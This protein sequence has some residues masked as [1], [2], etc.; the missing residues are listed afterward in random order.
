M[1]KNLTTI[2][3]AL[4]ALA[5]VAS[6]CGGGDSGDGELVAAISAQMRE[7]GDIPDGFDVECM[8]GAM[9]EGLGGAEVMEEEFGLTAETIADGQEPED[10]EMSIDNAR[11]MA[12]DMRECGLDQA[13]ISEIAGDGIPEDSAQCLLD[14]LDS[15]ALRDIFASSFV[16]DADAATLESGAEEALGAGLLAAIVECDV[17]IAGF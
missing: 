2:F 1:K 7:D 14:N 11:S 9:V 13:F 12:E 15:D 5:L 16:S 8:A 4:L 3:G 6:A 17:D 10:V